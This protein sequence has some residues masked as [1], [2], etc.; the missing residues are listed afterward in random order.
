[1]KVKD[2]T[3]IYENEEKIVERK[4]ERKRDHVRQ[5]LIKLKVIR[6]ENQGKNIENLVNDEDE[7]NDE[8]DAN[9]NIEE[10]KQ[11]KDEEIY[12]IDNNSNENE[13]D[14]D[15]NINKQLEMLQSNKKTFEIKQ[16]EKN[17]INN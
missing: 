10:I 15:N 13:N 3:E 17:N 5:K 6:S 2:K 11:M 4:I 8:D 1:M 7:D 14:N 12:D 9:N 16:Y